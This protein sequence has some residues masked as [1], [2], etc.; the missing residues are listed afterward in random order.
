MIIS[1]R[2]TAR[3]GVPVD[4]AR[5]HECLDRFA[6]DV[7]Y[8]NIGED[9]RIELCKCNTARQEEQCQ[10]ESSDFAHGLE[11]KELSV[12]ILVPPLSSQAVKTKG[13]QLRKGM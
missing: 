6:I 11:V 7:P 3:P 10:E 13:V 8:R 9:G 12:I 2:F 4:H 1:A 5:T